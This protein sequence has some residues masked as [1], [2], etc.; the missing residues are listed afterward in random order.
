MRLLHT[1]DWHLGR[2]LHGEDLLPHQAAFLDWLLSQALAHEA[3]AV[4]VAGEPGDAGAARAAA[5]GLGWKVVGEAS[6]ESAGA[7]P[8]FRARLRSLFPLVS[9]IVVA[10]PGPVLP[11]IGYRH[12]SAVSVPPG[13]VLKMLR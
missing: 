1:S 2:T 8:A 10:W 13:P 7:A 11:P 4:V 12:P 6:P 5:L 9:V 3:H